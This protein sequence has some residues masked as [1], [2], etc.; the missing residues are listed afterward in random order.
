MSRKKSERLAALALFDATVVLWLLRILVVIHLRTR[1]IGSGLSSVAGLLCLFFDF[2][3]GFVSSCRHVVRSF[4]GLF[5]GCRGSGIGG[6]GHRIAGGVGCGRSVGGGSIRSRSSGIGAGRS[7]IGVGLV[8]AS[9]IASRQTTGHGE[10]KKE[11]EIVVHGD[12]LV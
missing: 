1:C 4:G 12:V 10:R 6:I 7:R 3:S 9:A 2:G 11:S 8:F 5:D